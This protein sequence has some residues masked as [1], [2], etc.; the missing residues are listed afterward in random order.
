MADHVQV[1][2]ATDGT[3]INRDT[4]DPEYELDDPE[5]VCILKARKK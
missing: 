3:D 1:M 4:M 2:N 5:E